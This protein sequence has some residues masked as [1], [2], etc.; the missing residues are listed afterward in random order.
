[1]LHWM[2]HKLESRLLGEIS[3]ISETQMAPPLS[4]KD[5]GIRSHHFMA[6]R[7][8]NNGNNDR[9]YFWGSKITADG[10]C[11]HGLKRHLLLEEKL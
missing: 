1:M 9:F 7:G 11:S 8:G 10:D 3:I 4:N 2:K 5:H 6:N